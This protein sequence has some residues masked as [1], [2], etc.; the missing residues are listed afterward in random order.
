MPLSATQL[1]ARVAATNDGIPHGSAALGLGRELPERRMAGLRRLSGVPVW[2][3]RLRRRR[4]GRR[5]IDIAYK[6]SLQEISMK[7]V[8]TLATIVILALLLAMQAG[9][10][11][12]ALVT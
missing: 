2:V 6:T 9:M 4:A 11:Y 8:Q 5:R 12:Q 3:L 10:V 7:A 1:D